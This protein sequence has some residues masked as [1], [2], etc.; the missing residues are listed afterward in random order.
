MSFEEQMQAGFERLEDSVGTDRRMLRHT[1][2]AMAVVSLSEAEW[3]RRMRATGTKLDARV[4]VVDGYVAGYFA[5][6]R[7]PHSARL[8]PAI[9]D[10][11]VG[12]GL[13]LPNLRDG[14]EIDAQAR[15]DAQ[16]EWKL[17]RSIEPSAREKVLSGDT[18]LWTHALADARGFN[19]ALARVPSNERPAWR[20][21]ASRLSGV[22]A[23]WSRRTEPNAD[24]PFA[25]A[26]RE[27]GLS[28]LAGGSQRRPAILPTPT[29]DLAQAAF[30]LAQLCREV[31]DRPVESLL[32]RQL[33]TSIA[34]IAKAHRERGELGRAVRINTTALNLKSVSRE[35][36]TAPPISLI[37]CQLRFE[38]PSR[39]RS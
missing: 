15:A 17:P 39:P 31:H 10:V 16:T 4:N 27:V 28:A 38:H 20:W 12:G 34:A 24:G 11:E 26:A 19:E 25:A 7:D 33:V 35:I 23:L 8:G 14:W 13:S 32:V 6:W 3:I 9:T 36:R 37:S 5:Q 2:R 29:P 22:L 18:A 21:A 30:V 1:I